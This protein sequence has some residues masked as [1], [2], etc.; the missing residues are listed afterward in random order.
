MNSKNATFWVLLAVGVIAVTVASWFIGKSVASFV[1][2]NRGNTVETKQDDPDAERADKI[3]DADGED[4]SFDDS[5]DTSDHDSA[6]ET[7]EPAESATG[8]LEDEAGEPDGEPIPSAD[9]VTEKPAPGAARDNE[10]E[11]ELF[12]GDAPAREDTS[13]TETGKPKTPV[14]AEPAPVGGNVL[15]RVQIGAFSSRENASAYAADAAAKTGLQASPIRDASSGK[16]IF[17][18][19]CGA[20]TDKERAQNL[21][22]ELELQGYK[23][24]LSETQLSE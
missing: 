19:Q 18:V 15:Y 3:R 10:S 7:Q 2:K 16:D 1:L 17:R 20:F 24:H 12:G 23:V 4:L 21:M 13:D 5:R 22:R 6:L 11:D 9:S 14:K 8:S